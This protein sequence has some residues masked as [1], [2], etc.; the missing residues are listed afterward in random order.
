MRQPKS[1]SETGAPQAF[2]MSHGLRGETRNIHAIHLCHL[3]AQ[4]LHGMQ[5]HAQRFLDRQA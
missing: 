3:K 1:P 2:G 4:K 5:G